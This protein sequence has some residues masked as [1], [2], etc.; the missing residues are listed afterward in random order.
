[1]VLFTAG[2][3]RD[4]VEEHLRVGL[5]LAGRL[6]Q[7]ARNV[8]LANYDDTA[9]RQAWAQKLDQAKEV[10]QVIHLKCALKGKALHHFIS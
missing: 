8:K 2:K 4:T 6:G 5:V 3:V 7:R 1:M 10:L 9:T